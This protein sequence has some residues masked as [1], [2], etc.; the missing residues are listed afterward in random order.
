MG[1]PS[2]RV[3]RDRARMLTYGRIHH[4][5]AGPM[6]GSCYECPGEYDDPWVRTATGWRI[7]RRHFEI[8]VSLGDVAVLNPA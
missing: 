4:V 3:R 2:R 1:N 5:G 8:R 6:T 7:S